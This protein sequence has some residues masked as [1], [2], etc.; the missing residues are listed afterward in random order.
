MT[1]YVFS[2]V[3]TFHIWACHV[4]CVDKLSKI[5]MSSDALLIF[6]KVTKYELNTYACP[7]VIKTFHWES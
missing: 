4:A 5:F 1:S 3:T 6:S 7:K 2:I